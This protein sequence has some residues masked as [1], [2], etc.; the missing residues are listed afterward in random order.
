MYNIMAWDTVKTYFNIFIENVN[1][2]SAHHFSVKRMHHDG[3]N[4]KFVLKKKNIL[5]VERSSSAKANFTNDEILID[6]VKCKKK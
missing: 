6:V 3:D 5:G 2:F 4:M 1:I